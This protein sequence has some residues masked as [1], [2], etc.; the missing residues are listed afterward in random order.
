M[1]AVTPN[2]AIR[3]R[4][5]LDQR[6]N[7]SATGLFDSRRSAFIRAKTGDSCSFART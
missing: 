7:V 3:I 1:P 5:R 4:R 6:P 2:S